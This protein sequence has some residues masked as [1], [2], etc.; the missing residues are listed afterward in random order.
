[1]KKILKEFAKTIFIASFVFCFSSFSQ[2]PVS[3][4]E[5]KIPLESG[6]P[7]EKEIGG[8][9]ARHLYQL[10]LSAGQYVR[11]EAEEE[12]ADIVFMFMSLDGRNLLEVKNISQGRGRE[13]AEAAVPADGTYELRVISFAE[14]TGR[15][16]LKIAEKRKAAAKELAFSAGMGLSNEAHTLSSG[17]ASTA[18]DILQG[19]A[20]YEK[21]VEKFRAA[22][23]ERFVAGV[24]NNIGFAYE[25][26]GSRQRSIGYFQK[27]VEI[28]RHSTVLEAQFTHG[29]SLNNLGAA[30]LGLGEYQNSLEA[31]F[32]S[33]EVRRKTKH[34]RGEAKTLDNIGRVFEMSGD[35][36][37]ALLYHEKALEL[38]V[39][40]NLPVGDLAVTHNNFGVV[41]LSM[42]E[43]QNALE[44][45]R[46]A[47]Q[48]AR[49]A[50]N[51]RLEAAYASNL[52]RTFFTLGEPAEALELLASALEINRALGDK[53]GE[54]AT[55]R[56]L[57]QIYSGLGENEKS[58]ALLRQSLEIYRSLEAAPH[59]AET[60]LSLARAEK[61]NGSS[62]AARIT[63]EEAIGIVEKLRSRVRTADLR[64]SFSANLR[65][66]YDFYIELLMER[67]DGNFSGRAFE[68]AERSRSRGLLNLL[69]ESNA[70]IRTGVD[71]GLLRREVETRDLLSA[72]RENLTRVLS[73]KSKPEDV[74]GLQ[75][76]VE[77]IR[78]E[79]E[80][81][82]MEIRETS[83]RYSALTQPKTLTLAEI[84][85]D[86][87]DA[88]SVLLE[89]HLGE[90]KSFLWA[91]SK[92][93]FQ[94]FE[95]PA[96]GAIEQAARSF[97]EALTARNRRIKFETPG[98][99][100]K[101]VAA[102][103]SR[104][105]E[106]SNE[107]GRL[108][109]EPAKDFIRNKKL[110]IVADGGLQYVPFAAL[111]SPE[112][113]VR[114]PKSVRPDAGLFLIESNEIVT[115]PSASVLSV[116]RK[117]T[118]GRRPA[119]KTLV[120]LADPVFD[121][122]DERFQAAATKSG[123]KYV[124]AGSAK[125]TVRAFG[126]NGFELP[127]LEFTRREA[128]EIARLV[129]VSQR[130][131]I[132]DFDAKRSAVF[133][134]ELKN[135]RFLHFATHGFIN[136]QNP[137]LSGI[138]LSLFDENGREQDGFIRVGDIYNLD[139]S[140]ELV[141]LSGCR[142]GLG[143]AIK[144]EGLISLTRGFMYAGAKRVAVS[145]WDVSDEAT[146]ELM[147]KFYEGMLGNERRAPA[148]AIRQAQIAMIGDKKRGHPYYWAAFTIQGE[149]R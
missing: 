109:L 17:H 11:I 22:E 120:V 107:L 140:A 14:T 86:V 137:E 125:N 21:A 42:S 61:R 45:F 38:S 10:D 3:K 99:K 119:P 91:V 51:K 58:L 49:E 48:L 34:I 97:Y 9:F 106:L 40:N 2:T 117:E 27:A 5:E 145:L 78:A 20:V 47:L 15:Y 32:D 29:T 35:G 100:E 89:Y 70:D 67:R 136:Q 144:G 6:R 81:I 16:R 101:R 124:P 4:T 43:P 71:A 82:E 26:L 83:P 88:D 105:P 24:L 115:L 59:L 102:A 111:R 55:L 50:N 127:R 114:S 84:Q 139:L 112:S 129:P 93:G 39:K 12:G 25:R 96:A 36:E 62:E 60:L 44:A 128:A 72:R 132:L 63:A 118:A 46:K 98:E 41:H 130:A 65:A 68:A 74:A 110:L 80:R 104:I 54:A 149:P 103:D 28:V 95:L 56:Y 77:T 90:N 23:A 8:L 69:N 126:E 73:K 85:R 113:R 138:V 66:F 121:V 75:R 94:S 141:V 79:Y 1:M 53:P 133:T 18:A 33:L 76:E 19:I 148:G 87:L 31:F 134:G 7:F 146:A 57:G 92:N 147:A 123:K 64:D 52:G 131:Q 30:Y 116:L 135:Y 142:T 37:R 122:A 143:R 13:T 108:I